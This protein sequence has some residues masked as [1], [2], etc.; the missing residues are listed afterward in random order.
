[1]SKSKAPKEKGKGSSRRFYLIAGAV[2]LFAAAGVFMYRYLSE[3]IQIK[4]A[5]DAN[6][7]LR[8]EV[9][10]ESLIDLNDNSY[11]VGEFLRSGD[12]SGAPGS[13]SY[14]DNEPFKPY[15]SPNDFEKLKS[16][17]SDS[18]AWVIIPE[19]DMSFPV[20]H[21]EGDDTY[22]LYRNFNRESS[23]YG[24]AYIEDY[25]KSSFIDP[26][27]V[28][29]GHDISNGEWFGELQTIF[30]DPS[31]FERSRNIK[32]YLPNGERTYRV[33]AAVPYGR[34]HI[35]HY[36][37]FSEEKDYN[38]FIQKAVSSNSVNSRIDRDEIPEYG[39]P[40]LIF[41][42]CLKGD[43]SHRFLVL[44]YQCQ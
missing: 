40:L 19:T 44:A 37:D 11:D 36:Y 33:F 12:D 27:I 35:L 2:V 38:I 20:M 13:D 41:S 24:A 32:V 29:Y 15:T 23:I 25:N 26:C 1:M 39:T 8:G 21:H 42:T 17:N 31:R 28:I 43:Y 30:T 4:R 7:E 34:E 9:V 10:N 5:A 3:Q 16:K 18:V 6:R 14:P 22:Y